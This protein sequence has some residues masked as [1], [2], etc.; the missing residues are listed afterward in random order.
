MSN[1]KEATAEYFLKEGDMVYVV[2]F[3]IPL[4]FLMINTAISL[5]IDAQAYRNI[6]SRGKAIR[7][8]K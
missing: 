5:K 8:I 1:F 4:C 6:V 2:N 7:M 3:I